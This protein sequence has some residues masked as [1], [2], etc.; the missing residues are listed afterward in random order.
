MPEKP[1]ITWILVADGAKARLLAQTAA[2]APPTPVSGDYLANAE[3]RTPSRE[4]GADRPGRVQESADSAR[5]AMEPR[6]DW[7]R[8]AK[9]QFARQV[10]DALETAALRKEFEA[11]V[12]V[13]PPR[14]LGDLRAAIGPHA[15]ALVAAEIAK[16]LTNIPDHE[17]PEHLG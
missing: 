11:L 9:E 13:A 1:K 7:H 5:H 15:S 14:A 6:V 3:A 4:L 12:L 17:L 8:Y 10:A 16:D 2:K